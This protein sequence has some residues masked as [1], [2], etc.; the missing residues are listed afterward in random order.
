MLIPNYVKLQH[1]SLNKPLPYPSR[2]SVISLY[3]Q[4][5]KILPSLLPLTILLN[6]FIV[7]IRILVH[8]ILINAEEH[9]IGNRGAIYAE[10]D[11]TR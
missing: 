4:Q 9:V 1:K 6:K 11:L 10:V 3:G 8:T 5:N 7:G 2:R